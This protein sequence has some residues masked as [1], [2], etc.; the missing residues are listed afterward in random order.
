MTAFTPPGRR[1]PPLR[2]YRY[3]ERED[4]NLETPD[5]TFAMR[6]GWTLQRAA[7][8]PA[9]IKAGTIL[10]ADGD[11]LRRDGIAQLLAGQG[12]SVILASD[13]FE[14]LALILQGGIDL[15]VST[16]IMNHMDGLELLRALR[17]SAIKV[18]AVAISSGDREIDKVYLRVASLFGA[19][20]VHLQPL[21]PSA[22]LDDVRTLLHPS[23]G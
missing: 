8:D 20:R 11:F 23:P 7:D 13:G 16:T 22:F 14:A 4:C 3:A 19:A 12:Y 10:V 17:D 15:L 1:R 21:G 2:T 6:R 5:R 9:F 18:P